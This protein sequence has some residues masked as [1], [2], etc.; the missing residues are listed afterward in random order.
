MN[1]KLFAFFESIWKYIDSGAFY[2]QP[3]SVL[4]GA[5]AALN[6]LFPFV[7]LV[8]LI[9]SGAFGYM[10]GTLV[11]CTI[12]VLILLIFLALMS[13]SLWMN[14]RKKVQELM[15]ENHHFLAIPAV[16]HFIQTLGEWAGFYLGAGGCLMSLLFVFFTSGESLG[17]NELGLLPM[18]TGFAMIFIYPII[19]FLIVVSGR[20]IAELYSALAAIANNTRQLADRA[21]GEKAAAPRQADTPA[22]TEPDETATTAGKAATGETPTDTPPAD[23]AP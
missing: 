1:D 22:T 10:S 13:F 4:Y 15:K 7:V 11:F 19:G 12:L 18:Q 5:I 9:N 2:R 8:R 3:F 17:L 21:A 16:S 23:T 20:L 14:R 6:L